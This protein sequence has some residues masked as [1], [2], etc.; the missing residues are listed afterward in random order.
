MGL[1][2]E[3]RRGVCQRSQGYPCGGRGSRAGTRARHGA[4]SQLQRSG[5]IHTGR[6]TVTLSI[7]TVSGL[8]PNSMMR[9]LSPCCLKLGS[10]L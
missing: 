1:L 10:Y 9:S 7:D 3:A 6:P 8:P 2:A 5:N 4:P